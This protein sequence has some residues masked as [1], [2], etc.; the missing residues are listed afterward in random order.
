MFNCYMG[1]FLQK[2]PP[3]GEWD[4]I[5]DKKIIQKKARRI[6]CRAHTNFLKIGYHQKL[7]TA[8]SLHHSG[9]DLPQDLQILPEKAVERELKYRNNI[10]AKKKRTKKGYFF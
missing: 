1:Q 7:K 2:D 5:S 9:K 8:R 3:M 6:L 10:V 4:I